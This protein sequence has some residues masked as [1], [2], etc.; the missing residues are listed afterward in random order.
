MSSY[1]NGIGCL[2][3]EQ[4]NDIFYHKITGSSAA[5][6]VACGLPLIFLEIL[7]ITFVPAGFSPISLNLSECRWQ[8]LD[9]P[10][11]PI[12]LPSIYRKP[13]KTNVDGHACTGS[14]P[15]MSILR[16]KKQK[17]KKKVDKQSGHDKILGQKYRIA[18][19][20]SLVDYVILDKMTL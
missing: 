11:V 16:S 13:K 1:H 12:S 4:G 2:I 14:S 5:A 20:A 17:K 6:S 15:G 9:S 19:K 18:M 3:V 7:I 10:A 8:L